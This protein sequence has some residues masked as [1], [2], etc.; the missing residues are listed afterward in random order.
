MAKEARTRR[1]TK[2]ARMRELGA[3]RGAAP[4]PAAEDAAV[5]L[6]RQ[7]SSRLVGD[8]TLTSPDVERRVGM[9]MER[10]RA[11]WRAL[12]FP[13]VAED[14]LA[15]SEADVEV[16]TRILELQREQG[17]GDDIVL[18]LVRVSGQALARIAETEAE[19]FA[20]ADTNVEPTDVSVLA[21]RLTAVEPFLRYIWRRHLAAAVGRKIL[22]GEGLAGESV[23]TVGFADLVGF[24]DL[25]RNLEA[26]ALAEVIARFERNVYE[27]VPR[28]N[29]RVIKMLG[30]EVMFSV[31][32][33]ADG[34]EIALDLID[35]HA[36]DSLLPAIR[37]GIACGPALAWE[38]DLFGMTV[39][40]ASRLVDA[41]RPSTVLMSSEMAIALADNPAYAQHRL[42]RLK[43]KGFGLVR[44][45]RL[46]RA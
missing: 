42:R 20:H 35:L 19:I 5:Q 28:H 31:A 17:T 43:L 25:S 8:P 4:A 16:L 6:W 2:L 37:A 10:L 9:P 34:A 23:V 15:F 27:C 38:G 1:S 21:A 3:A 39:N 24:T 29:G 22:G 18:Q 33:A 11:L 44:A 46:E 14:Q 45:C 13:P 41:A 32:V 40:L 12:G 26:R 7:L 36:N 30:D